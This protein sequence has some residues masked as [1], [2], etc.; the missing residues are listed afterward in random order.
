MLQLVKLGDQHGA[1][2]EQVAII[3]KI[4]IDGIDS[5]DFKAEVPRREV[6]NVMAAL[7]GSFRNHTDNRK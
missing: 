4:V 3:K 5:C 2:E 6:R 7:G 1:Y